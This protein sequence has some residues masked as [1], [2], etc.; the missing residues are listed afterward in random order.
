MKQIA[1]VFT[2][3][4]LMMFVA[5]EKPD[6]NTTAE[7]VPVAK[8][9]LSD[10]EVSE[11]D[12]EIIDIPAG[13]E[14]DLD[15]YFS[16]YARIK[17][18]DGTGFHL[19][20]EDHVDKEFIFKI[21][22]IFDVMFEEKERSNFGEKK[23]MIKK[24]L[25]AQNCCFCL[26]TSQESYL[27]KIDSLENMELKFGSCVMNESY[28]NGDVDFIEHRRHDKAYDDVFSFII[29]HGIK[30]VSPTFYEK[31]SQACMN[32]ITHQYYFPYSEL[33]IDECA[34]EYFCLLMDIHY[35]NWNYE[36]EDLLFE[37]YEYSSRE[38]IINNDPEGATL[39]DDFL[40]DDIYIVNRIAAGFKGDLFLNDSSLYPYTRKTQF[41]ESAQ[42]TGTQ[43]S[44][45]FGNA[46]D[47]VL[48]GNSGINT[49]NGY[50]GDDIIDGGAGVDS[51]IYSFNY[52]TNFF[53]IYDDSVLVQHVVYGNDFLQNIEYL[54]FN[55]STLKID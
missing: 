20:I 2:L 18:Q 43:T 16:S 39:I 8:L 45:V 40:T 11:L 42:L 7:V 26:F 10:I 12:F 53:K 19:L 50:Q 49:F 28:L 46:M 52:D 30:K 21:K 3:L 9:A 34:E 4:A 38:E 24:S 44:N 55:D 27:S 33:T 35:G 36:N 54:I 29:R 51:V 47:N 31:I 1:T 41:W 6:D 17:A 25:A 15:Q 5:C 48:I 13:V 14:N 22:Q 23:Y 37:K 32:A